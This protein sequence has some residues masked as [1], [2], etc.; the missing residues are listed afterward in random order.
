MIDRKRAR[1]L[2][3]S[4]LF[5]AWVGALAATA[6]A[7]ARGPRPR[8]EPIREAGPPAPDRSR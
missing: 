6:V 1:F 3:A 5:L 4:A 7:T 8:V 2:A